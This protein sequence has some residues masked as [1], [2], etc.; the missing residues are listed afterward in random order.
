[1]CLGKNKPLIRLE[2]RRIETDIRTVRLGSGECVQVIAG[3][4]EEHLILGP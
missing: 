4:P 1:M 2:V 3:H